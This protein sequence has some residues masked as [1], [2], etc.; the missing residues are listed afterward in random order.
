MFMYTTAEVARILKVTP[1]KLTRWINSKQPPSLPSIRIG[2]R[3]R[4]L[5]EDLLKFVGSQKFSN[6]TEE[7]DHE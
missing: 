1:T 2:K 7:G 4:F 6:E 3:R 5:L